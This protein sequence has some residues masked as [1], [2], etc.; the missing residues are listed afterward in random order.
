MSARHD[1]RI[2][3]VGETDNAFEGALFFFTAV[4]YLC[5][6]LLLLFVTLGLAPV[7]AFQVVRAPL[8]NKLLLQNFSGILRRGVY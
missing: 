5:S 2:S 8:Q 3:W 6:L 7:D 4:A 1:Y